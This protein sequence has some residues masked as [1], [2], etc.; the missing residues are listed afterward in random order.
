MYQ[1]AE[2]YIIIPAELNLHECE[3]VGYRSEVD[4][5]SC[6]HGND[7]GCTGELRSAE[8]MFTITENKSN[9]R[10]MSG[11]RSS[12]NRFH[13]L[14]RDGSTFNGEPGMRVSLHSLQSV[15]HKTILISTFYI[16]LT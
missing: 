1:S 11:L 5:S 13:L 10:T 4:D 2:P 14:A 9:K 15:C 6:R 7:R 8:N 12:F 3:A 16:L